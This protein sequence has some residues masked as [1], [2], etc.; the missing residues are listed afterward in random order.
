MRFIV[1]LQL[2]PA[3]CA[4][5]G[6]PPDGAVHALALGLRS[7]PDIWREAVSTR[8]TI[9]TKDSDFPQFAE[10]SRSAQV[11]WIRV[12]N[13]SNADHF[14]KVV[15]VWPEVRRQIEVGQTIVEVR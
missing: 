6:S 15:A 7:D 4:I 3:L 10:Q 8:S 11:V 13:C 5:V 12:G 9:V 2:S 14:R 1:D